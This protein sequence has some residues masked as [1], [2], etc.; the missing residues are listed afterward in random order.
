MKNYVQIQRRVWAV[1]DTHTI[2]HMR[3]PNMGVKYVIA[4]VKL[5]SNCL[6]A[7]CSSRLVDE[8]KSL[9]GFRTVL[10]FAETVLY[11]AVCVCVMRVSYQTRL[12]IWPKNSK[13]VERRQ[14]WIFAGKTLALWKHLKT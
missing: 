14:N 7:I 3:N 13:K 2:A 8:A 9:S 10:P 4:G 12:I 6:F 5:W 1:Y 11:A